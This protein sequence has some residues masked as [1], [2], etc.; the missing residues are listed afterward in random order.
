MH[1]YAFEALGT[2]FSLTIWDAISASAAGEYFDAARRAADAFDAQYSRFKSDSLVSRLSSE[3]GVFEVPS[4]LV[5]ML[6]LY[7]KLNGATAGALNPAI[8]FALADTGYDA[9]YSLR[10]GAVIRD[11]PLFSD[12]LTIRDDTHIELKKH[13]LLDLGA[14]GK[15]YLVDQLAAAQKTAGLTRFLVDGSGDLRYVSEA[16]EPI[17]VGLEHP[18]DATKII[19]T[20]VLTSGALCGS[21]TNRRTWGT[22]NHYFNPHTKESPQDVLATWVV[23]DTAACADGLSSAL[24]FTEPETLTPFNFEYCMVNKDMQRKNSAGFAAEFFT[25]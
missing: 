17:I 24:F 19:G 3:R 15:G 1:T 5:S 16:K 22:R 23:A 10:E 11:V 20:V 21:A 8:G 7:E 4:D 9:V 2:K 18:L 13:I 25:V 12:A 6:R 14:V